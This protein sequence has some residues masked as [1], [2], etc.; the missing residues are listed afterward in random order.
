MHDWHRTYTGR[1]IIC[2]NV[3]IFPSLQSFPQCD[4]L[5]PGVYDL[6]SSLPHRMVPKV[7]SFVSSR[8]VVV[9][10]RLGG[11]QQLIL[12]GPCDFVLVLDDFLVPESR[13]TLP[14]LFHDRGSA[15]RFSGSGPLFP[16]PSDAVLLVESPCGRWC[17]VLKIRHGSQKGWPSNL[18]RS[19]YSR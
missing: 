1:L 9:A 7:V 10:F 17:C 5:L 11:C 18:L 8:P 12:H 6:S 16:S 15:D 4:V 2:D 14:R 13:I 3:I 19:C